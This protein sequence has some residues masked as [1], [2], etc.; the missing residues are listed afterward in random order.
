MLRCQLDPV[1]GGG[2]LGGG[3]ADGVEGLLAHVAAVAPQ[4]VPLQ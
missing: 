4:A 3:D 1:V 2:P